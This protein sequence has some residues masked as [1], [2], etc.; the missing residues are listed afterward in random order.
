[1]TV[2]DNDRRPNYTGNGV[3]VDFDFEFKVNSASEVKVYADGVEVT[4]GI[5]KTLLNGGAGGGT[6]TFSTAPAL[7]V[8][9][10]ITRSVAYT[11]ATDLPVVDQLDT[12]N[13]EDA[14]DKNVMLIQ[15]LYDLTVRSLKFPLTYVGSASTEIP[16]PA[17]NTILGWKSDLTALENKSL[18]TLNTALLPS[19]VGKD[20]WFATVDET[21]ETLA[22][23]QY[24]QTGDIADDAVTLAKMAAGTAGKYIGYDGSGNPTELSIESDLPVP[25][26][27]SASTLTVG[28]STVNIATAGALGLE[29]GSA[30]EGT[31]HWVY[32]YECK[33]SSGT[34]YVLSRTNEQASGTITAPTGYTTSKRQFR[35]A[36]RNDSSG[37][38]IP[39]IVG[40]G[41]PHRP[42]IKLLTAAS[43]WNG[44]SYGN[45]SITNV[46]ANG[47]ATSDT[48]VPL[49]SYAPPFSKLVH[50]HGLVGTGTGQFVFKPTGG[51]NYEAALA[52]WTQPA[53]GAV[54]VSTNASQSIDYKRAAGS[55]GELWLDVL[56]FTVT[57]FTT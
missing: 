45:A 40:E 54:E 36:I 46:L 6:V 2:S 12:E 9:V 48:A 44:S 1:M 53:T 42:Y 32:L 56:G 10:L 34:T 52:G 26:Y 11:Q 29:A 13:I 23:Q 4:S 28:G 51:S 19:M 31:S 39:W 14:L 35:F 7:G 55:S 25:I 17:A 3:T 47:T 21:G 8:V 50:L 49:A 41:W 33:G 37:N 27:A 24:V 18:T 43:H 20:T 38:F 22:W 5:T 16:T 57:E 30:A 15:Q